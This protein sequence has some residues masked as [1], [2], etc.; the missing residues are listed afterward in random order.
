V[1]AVYSGR[2]LMAYEL[3]LQN[4]SL[5]ESHNNFKMNQAKKLFVNSLFDVAVCELVFNAV[6]FGD[7]DL[8]EPG[9]N[10]IDLRPQ[11]VGG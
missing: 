3:R 9:E 11:G 1:S 6:S 8:D 5:P 2:K 4:C 7:A 10:V